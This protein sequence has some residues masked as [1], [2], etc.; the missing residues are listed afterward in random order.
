MPGDVILGM[1]LDP[2]MIQPR[3]VGD[4]VEHQ[5]QAALAEPLAQPGQ[6]RVAAE[7]VDA[8]CSR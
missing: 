7:V 8:P 3:V 4:E 1:I 5:P 2:G 6:G